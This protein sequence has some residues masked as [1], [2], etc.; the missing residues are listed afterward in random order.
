MASHCTAAS[1]CSEALHCTVASHCSAQAL[2]L[3]MWFALSRSDPSLSASSQQCLV[4]ALPRKGRWAVRPTGK[5][6][7]EPG[8]SLGDPVV[9]GTMDSEYP[10]HTGRLSCMSVHPSILRHVDGWVKVELGWCRVAPR[11]IRASL[12]PEYKSGPVHEA[13][14]GK[15]LVDR[16]SAEV[17]EH[18]EAHVE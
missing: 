7:T 16:G 9:L 8:L 11:V 6:D 14:L 15:R 12:N 2:W 18:K 10:V 1:H 5:A 13:I 3:R 4:K 17:L